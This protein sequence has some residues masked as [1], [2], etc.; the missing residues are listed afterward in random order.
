MQMTASGRKRLVCFQAEVQESWPLA[1]I[2]ECSRFFE[3]L[4]YPPICQAERG[5]MSHERSW[6]PPNGGSWR[7]PSAAARLSLPPAP[8]QF[9]QKDCLSRG[10][11]ALRAHILHK[12]VSATASNSREICGP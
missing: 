2:A 11:W 1:G 4:A 3:A 9:D 7:G 12:G 10:C 5:N 8:A 6:T